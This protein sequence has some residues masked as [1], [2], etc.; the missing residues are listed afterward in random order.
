[1]SISQSDIDSLL[2]AAAD[3]TAE[4]NAPTAPAP[5]APA[6]RAPRSEP[7]DVKPAPE[8]L[9]RILHMRVPVIVT[10]AERDMPVASVLQLTAGSILEF[11]RHADA[12]LDLLVN[13]KSIGLGQAVKVGENFGLRITRLGEVRDTI[14][15]LGC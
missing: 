5:S 2:S 8:Q 9:R 12:E 6:A 14:K 15:A 11:E 1:M 10:L 3:L 13:N 4:A 7:A